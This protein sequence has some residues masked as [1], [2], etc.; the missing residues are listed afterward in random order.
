MVGVTPCSPGSKPLRD[1]S[2]EECGRN[3]GVTLDQTEKYRHAKLDNK[4][5]LYINEGIRGCVKFNAA[6]RMIKA[7]SGCSSPWINFLAA[8][9]LLTALS[10]KAVAQ[11][12]APNVQGMWA[13]GATRDCAAKPYL[14]SLSDTESHF[15]DRAGNVDEEQVLSRRANGFTTQTMRSST[16]PMGTQWDYRFVNSDNVVVHNLTSGRSFNLARCLPLGTGTSENPSIP[17]TMQARSAE[18]LG[19]YKFNERG[20]AGE[21]TV[22][23]VP[24]CQVSNVF[25]CSARTVF[26]V[27]ILSTTRGD[28][29]RT[30]EVHAFE[31]AAARVVGSGKTQGTFLADSVRID[32]MFSAKGALIDGRNEAQLSG[33][34]GM[35][36][37]FVGTWSKVSRAPKTTQQ[38]LLPQ[39]SSPDG[40]LT[41][42]LSGL[43]TW[44]CSSPKA[45]ENINMERAVARHGVENLLRASG[46]NKLGEGVPL[47]KPLANFAF[48]ADQ[49]TSY[50]PS[51]ENRTLYV[52]SAVHVNVD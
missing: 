11:Q 49:W 27:D 44:I 7:N 46:C 43:N 39:G 30:C 5:E 10:T 4:C 40:S 14:W 31:D 8:A 41:Q 1:S 6:E 12:T 35:N 20:F 52:W 32:I 42:T 17:A 13:V 51:I 18:L 26:K 25:G 22:T 45:W 47:S 19:V 21:M 38:A 24:A 37:S 28:N 48:D 33:F 23:E 15:Q 34:C 50:A 36:G 29:P 16:V 2:G 9:S 3:E